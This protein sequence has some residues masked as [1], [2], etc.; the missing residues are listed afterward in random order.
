MNDSKTV[1]VCI[2]LHEA[3]HCT[4]PLSTPQCIYDVQVKWI[5][6]LQMIECSISRFSNSSKTV[7]NEIIMWPVCTGGVVP[8]MHFI[9]QTSKCS[10][11]LYNHAYYRHEKLL[12]RKV[13]CKIDRDRNFAQICK[14]A[15][16]NIHF[17]WWK[18]FHTRRRD[19]VT[20]Q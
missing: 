15:P 4:S 8:Q 2:E 10:A 11:A 1:L 3:R 19:H 12:K 20:L 17:L 6:I 9:C 7:D 16:C 18:M 13:H 14:I 5:F